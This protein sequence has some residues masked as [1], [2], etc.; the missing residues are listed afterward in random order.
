MGANYSTSYVEKTAD[1]FLESQPV[2]PN[3]LQ[4]YD[5]DLSETS[6][7]R[8]LKMYLKQ[9][10]GYIEF[11][12]KNPT[13]LNIKMNEIAN[14]RS[15]IQG[16]VDHY[17]V[18]PSFSYK[19]KYTDIEDQIAKQTYAMN[20][21][22]RKRRSSKKR[23]SFGRKR[24]SSVTRKSIRSPKKASG[25]KASGISLKSSAAGIEGIEG[26]TNHFG[27]NRRWSTKYKRSIN[28]KKPKGFSQK[29]YCTYG[30]KK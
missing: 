28:C 18:S 12:Q 27:R 3:R 15:N 23:S 22:G 6:G 24:R 2:G 16:L 30:R 20:T 4:K 11:V 21:F 7:F 25:E 9:Y 26:S 5:A 14:V 29:Q 19:T 17:K 8:K 10:I 1:K 13:Q